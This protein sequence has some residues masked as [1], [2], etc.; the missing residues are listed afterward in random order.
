VCD[1]G[2]I[3]AVLNR[4][5]VRF[6]VIG[7]MAA[8][9]RDLPVP[10]TVDIDITP[11]REPDNLERLAAAFDELEAGLLTADRGGHIARD[12]TAKTPKPP[13]VES[14]SGVRFSSRVWCASSPVRASPGG[15]GTHR[16]TSRSAC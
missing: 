4:H 3:V 9:V 7:G 5:E 12:H 14:R 10:A 11:S 15:R 16:R 13:L 1:P 2:A 6:V 8:M